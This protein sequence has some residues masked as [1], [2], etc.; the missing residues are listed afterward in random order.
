[1]PQYLLVLEAFGCFQLFIDKSKKNGSWLENQHLRV[2]ALICKLHFNTLTRFGRI[3]EPESQFSCH[4]N[5]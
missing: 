2:F 3:H 4:A 5:Q 1:M